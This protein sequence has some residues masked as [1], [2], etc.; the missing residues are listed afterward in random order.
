MKKQILAWPTL[1]FCMSTAV[2]QDAGEGAKPA[3]ASPRAVQGET[4]NIKGQAFRR[5]PPER[6]K[7]YGYEVPE[8][9]G[10]ENA[11][12]LYLD[13]INAAVDPPTDLQEALDAALGGAWPEG[14]PGERL[15]AW[16]EENEGSLE[17][18][19]RAAYLP[20]YYMPPLIMGDDDNVPLINVVLPPLAP[21]RQ[22]A[23][24]LAARAVYLRSQG[25]ADEAL[26]ELLVAHRMG[27]QISHG[28]TLIEGL[29]GSAIDALAA[30]GFTQIAESGEARPEALKATLA[31]MD[32]LST[33][34]PNWEEMI[35]REQLSG[36]SFID[37]MIDMPGGLSGFGSGFIN[38]ASQGDSTGWSMLARR[39]KRLYLPDRVMKKQL[40]AYYDT[41][42]SA[43]RP[44]EDGTIVTIEEDKLFAAISPWNLPVRIIAPSLSRANELVRRTE[45]NFLRAKLAV[46][47]AAYQTEK[48]T[49]PPVLSALVPE[50]IASVPPD[51]ITGADFDY[52]VVAG[53][54]P[55]VKGLELV[56]RDNEA[57]ILKKRRSAAILSPRAARW[58]R[59]VQSAGERYQFTEAQRA[60]ADAILREL[61]ARA[62][63]YEESEG[64]K[65]KAL[66]EAD[67]PS[68]ELSH[69]LG[70]LDKIFDELKKRVEALPTA[71]Q[72]RDA[73]KEQPEAR[74]PSVKKKG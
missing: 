36:Q 64:A 16:L 8:L 4:I 6:L 2:A 15:A 28:N 29:V 31:E 73:A 19:R 59:Y 11:A 54:R 68:E 20:D 71:E 66:V 37:D 33:S 50:Y 18:A 74:P 43:G 63:R 13:A 35:R 60:S 32:E 23:R 55:A 14:E 69:K 51:P 46:A 56:T 42:A 45:G 70:P 5:F 57:E 26:T 53:E 25:R 38:P 17:L 52:Q 48:G 9:A 44:R 62:A 58:R 34:L 61:E 22:L 10:E 40:R 30:K 49:P 24:T 67:Q 39:L 3:S 27:N 72:R 7:Q 12:Y 21:Q 47:A 65:L 1:I 41:L